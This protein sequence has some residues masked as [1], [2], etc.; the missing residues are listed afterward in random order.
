MPILSPKQIKEE[1]DKVVIGQ[2][3]A[4]KDLAIVAYNHNLR[5]YR[6]NLGDTTTIGQLPRLISLIAGGTGSGKTLLV[7]TLANYLNLPWYKIDATGISASG[8]KGVSIYDFLKFYI[9][10]YKNTYL[11]D[12]L[13]YGIIYIDEIDKLGGELQTTNSGNYHREIQN[14]L[15][16]VTEG[17]EI[18]ILG[19]SFGR[20]K[21]DT[22]KL[23][24]IFSG[25]FEGIVR[26]RHFNKHRPGFNTN[27]EE[28]LKELDKK[29]TLEELEKA[30]IIKELIGRISV[31]SYTH[32]L[33]KEQIKD[34]MFNC[35]NS[36]ISQYESLYYLSGSTLTLLDEVIDR[37][38][39][40]V[41]NGAYG[42][43]YLKTV[44]YEELRNGLFELS[45][46]NQIEDN[47]LLLL[48]Q[49][50]NTDLDL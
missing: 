30:G 44:L 45:T 36:I 49:D 16:T 24:F 48:E 40:K 22:S 2:D 43:R 39:D 28:E 8:F 35:Y 47:N 50:Q 7:E 23:L 34:V 10:K 29:I 20:Y 42:M 26:D 12:S 14:G 38:I 19:T 27:H 25:A 13:N 18:E 15:L 9:E 6:N 17:T 11:S 3:E 33:S 21:L 31:I 32:K 46:S 4:K 41:Y 37:V 1:L 5:Y